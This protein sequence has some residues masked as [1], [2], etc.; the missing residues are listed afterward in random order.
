VAGDQPA[1]LAPFLPW[2]IGTVAFSF[3]MAWAG[4]EINEHSTAPCSILKGATDV[5]EQIPLFMKG[6]AGC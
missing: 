3:L 2:A 1:S 5:C 6:E 4:I